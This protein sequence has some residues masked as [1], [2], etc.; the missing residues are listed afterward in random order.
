MNKFE[1]SLI[2][3]KKYNSTI[4]LIALSVA[5]SINSIQVLANRPSV[6]A[7]LLSFF[8]IILIF[9]IYSLID[10]RKNY[11]KNPVH[12][13]WGSLV[14]EFAAS[15]LGTLLMKLHPFLVSG[16]DC[17]YLEASASDFLPAVFGA[18]ILAFLAATVPVP[19]R[20]TRNFSN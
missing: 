3:M 7:S 11:L 10:Q 5:I 13:Y 20:I 14:V 9:E 18:I 2:L 6:W 8:V 12:V 17:R 1:P 16:M 4:S 15:L 19:S